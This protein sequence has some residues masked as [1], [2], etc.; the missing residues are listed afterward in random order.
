MPLEEFIASIESE[1]EPE[2]GFFWKIRQGDFRENDFSRALEKFAAVPSIAGE[3]VPARLV[4]ILWYVPIFM[5]WQTDRVRE[6]GCSMAAYA[7]ASTSLL[8]E[9]ERILGV[10]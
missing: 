8:N 4:S 9:V 5:E 3:L 2:T 10:L 6:R 7:A 1:S